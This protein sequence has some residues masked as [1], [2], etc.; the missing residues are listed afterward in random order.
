MGERFTWGSLIW[1]SRNFVCMPGNE[2]AVRKL[3]IVTELRNDWYKPECQFIH[4]VRTHLQ[5]I[6]KS[7]LP[8]AE[9]HLELSGDRGGMAGH[10]ICITHAFRTGCPSEDLLSAA[11]DPVGH[12]LP[13]S[14]HH[15]GSSLICLRN[16][17][18]SPS[19]SGGF[20]CL[21]SVFVD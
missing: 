5:I 12:R 13:M 4:Q 1:R 17:C 6:C 2:F 15:S 20:V 19:S 11:S 7:S 3:I 10:A 14:L 16:L 18:K 21:C 9:H 8:W